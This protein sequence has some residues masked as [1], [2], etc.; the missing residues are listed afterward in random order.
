VTGEQRLTIM[1]DSRIC[2][3]RALALI[4][5]IAGAGIALLAGMAPAAG[6][7]WRSSVAHAAP[8]RRRSSS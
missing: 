6:G 1:K 7:L 5:A 3:Y 2:S 4:L 8:A